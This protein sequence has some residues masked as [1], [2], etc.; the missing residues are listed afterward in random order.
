[1]RIMPGGL[2]YAVTG[3]AMGGGNPRPSL[4]WKVLSEYI[5]WAHDCGLY[6]ESCALFFSI[7][8]KSRGVI[9]LFRHYAL[10]KNIAKSHYQKLTRKCLFS[11]ESCSI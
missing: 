10:K 6:C 3:N 8:L 5:I 1:M 4:V 11:L 2:P 7:K 9:S